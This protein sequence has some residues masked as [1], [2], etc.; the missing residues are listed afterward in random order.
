MTTELTEK[1]RYFDSI[2][3][4]FNQFGFAKDVSSFIA[5]QSC[6]ETD[7]GRSK[8]FLSNHNCFGMKYPRKRITLAMDELNN[9]ALYYSE[10]F[11]CVDYILWMCFNRF[12]QESHED[13]D[14]FQNNLAKSLFNPY[15]DYISRIMSIYDQYKNVG[16]K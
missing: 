14:V 11:S 3:S 9:H 10:H 6:L 8:V 1:E 13:L 16:L 15:S 12:P 2:R 7:F 4:K 5:A